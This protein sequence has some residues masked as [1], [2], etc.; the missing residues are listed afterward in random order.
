MAEKLQPSQNE[1][2]PPS[3]SLLS[4]V[5]QYWKLNLPKS[6]SRM[7][8][9]DFEKAVSQAENHIAQLVSQGY[10][11]SGANE[12]V[13]PSLFPEPESEEQEQFSEIYF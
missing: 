9:Q 12:V 7:S 4:R 10:S 2:A 8:P 1:P 3:P 5:K 11:L 13:Y 6:Y